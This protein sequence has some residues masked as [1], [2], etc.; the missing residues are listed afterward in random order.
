MKSEIISRILKKVPLEIR[1]RVNIQM[2]MIDMLTEA[3][4]REDKMWGADEDVQF[5]K[6]YECAEKLAK[7]LLEAIQEWEEDGRPQDKQIK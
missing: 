4:Y 6:I 3:G 1:L 7:R 2:G 5:G